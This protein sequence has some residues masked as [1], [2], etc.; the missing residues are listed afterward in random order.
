MQRVHSD[1]CRAAT[2][3]STSEVPLPWSAVTWGQVRVM[4][5]AP[6]IGCIFLQRVLRC[7]LVLRVDPAKIAVV[8]PVGCTAVFGPRI[9]EAV[10]HVGV[11]PLAVAVPCGQ[12]QTIDLPAHNAQLHC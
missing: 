2:V 11:L 5:G 6:T 7:I 8:E 10:V 4:C 1:L 3:A 9:K 12:Q